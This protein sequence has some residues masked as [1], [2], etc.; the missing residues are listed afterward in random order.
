MEKREEQRKSQWYYKA[1]APRC[2]GFGGAFLAAGTG[3]E[4][5]GGVL[6]AAGL[7]R[8]LL[9]D[10]VDEV[11]LSPAAAVLVASTGAVTCAASSKRSNHDPAFA[12]KDLIAVQPYGVH[13]R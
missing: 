6:A 7:A 13:A 9:C 2:G 1:E 10:I 12:K 4:A 11:M 3:L 8:G 5:A